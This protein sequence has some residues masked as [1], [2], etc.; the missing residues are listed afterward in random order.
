MTDRQEVVNEEVGTNVLDG[1]TM[2]VSTILWEIRVLNYSR[3][4]AQ[5]IAGS[6]PLGKSTNQRRRRRRRA[7]SQK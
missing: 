6:S 3:R 4:I 7:S 5:D 1:S 2:A